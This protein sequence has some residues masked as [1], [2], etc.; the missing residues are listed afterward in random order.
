MLGAAI[1]AWL[2]LFGLANYYRPSSLAG[3]M[4]V[5]GN[6][7]LSSDPGTLT[8]PAAWLNAVFGLLIPL[9][10]L[11]WVSLSSG[12]EHSYELSFTSRASVLTLAFI[13]SCLLSVPVAA[14]VLGFV[15]PQFSTAA[16]VL[17]E[18]AI[19]L[20]VATVGVI[21][22][23]SQRPRQSYLVEPSTEDKF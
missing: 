18:I 10:V 13:A 15:A 22:L 3:L 12:I 5:A 7:A 1:S 23:T 11:T 19:I 6:A 14:L 17:M 2:I 4:I 16:S 9:Y 20:M 21:V 8:V